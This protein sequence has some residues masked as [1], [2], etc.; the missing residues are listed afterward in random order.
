[1]I[2]YSGLFIRGHPLK[3]APK[4]R[5]AWLLWP[6]NLHDKEWVVDDIEILEEEGVDFELFLKISNAG[7][8]D[9]EFVFKLYEI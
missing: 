9:E 7:I 4:L 1:M 2:E 3:I 8:S 6:L 5:L